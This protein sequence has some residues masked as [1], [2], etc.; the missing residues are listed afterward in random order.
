LY[1][2]LNFPFFGLFNIR[3][4]RNVKAE[5]CEEHRHEAIEIY[6]QP[7]IEGFF[8]TPFGRF[9]IADNTAFILPANIIH[10][11]V[12]IPVKKHAW[13]TIF[14]ISASRLREMM[15]PLTFHS[16]DRHFHW[17]CAGQRILFIEAEK[18]KTDIK[19]L[20]ELTDSPDGRNPGLSHV[21][22]VFSILKTVL[23]EE[24]NSRLFPG[25]KKRIADSRI[26]MVID[27]IENNYDR[28]FS[29]ENIS[30]FLGVS[31]GYICRLFREE[32]GSTMHDYLSH[33][34]IFKATRLLEQGA[35]NITRVAMETGFE[36][37]NLL[38]K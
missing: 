35:G 24:R 27:Y 38:I 25:F 31:K 34:R 28:K 26:S 7:G 21:F 33:Y 4:N 12:S 18:I 15:K 22:T 29:L 30:E 3:H 5:S 1:L 20:V 32:T 10:S 6:L 23:T 2:L 37:N 14:Q 16:F 19:Q 17:I 9:S 13:K 36:D 11:I 8:L